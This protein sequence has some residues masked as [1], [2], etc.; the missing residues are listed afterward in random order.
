MMG[1]F[2][3]LEKI[4]FNFTN[5]CKDKKITDLYEFKFN[6]SLLNFNFFLIEKILVNT[7]LQSQINLILNVKK[8]IIYLCNTK[9]N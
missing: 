4:S 6:S 9:S 8:E 5:K 2:L 7:I 1:I 3:T